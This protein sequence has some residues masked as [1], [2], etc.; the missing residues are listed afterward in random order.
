LSA[1]LAASPLL[2]AEPK[3]TRPFY[4][5]FTDDDEVRIGGS[6]APDIEKRL[7]ILHDLLLET[8]LDGIGHKLGE[9]SQHPGFEFHFEIVDSPEI[10]AFSIS[11]GYIYVNRGLL[12]FVE[13]EDELAGALGHEIGHVVAYHGTND[14]SRRA[15]VAKA[16]EQGKKIRALDSQ[17]AQDLLN[18]YGGPLALFAGRKFTRDEESQ[19]DLLAIYDCLRAGWNPNGLV[20]M[21]T[22]FGR[23]S[24]SPT[25]I[26]AIMQTHPSPQ[27]RSGRCSKRDPVPDRKPFDSDSR[28]FGVQ[29]RQGPTEI[30]SA[31]TNAHKM[32]GA[33]SPR[34]AGSFRLGTP[35]L[36]T[37]A[38]LHPLTTQAVRSQIAR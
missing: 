16:I 26:E 28:Q 13:S 20:A 9:A 19:A 5:R 25:L 1:I 8:Y 33:V 30:P 34:L 23:Y 36:V 27:A 24:G 18:R 35:A 37:T 15:L 32:T 7:P 6:A 2:A 12:S 17:Q 22:R 31:T 10:N 11:G 3:G 14:I 21:L 38:D 4:N 29:S